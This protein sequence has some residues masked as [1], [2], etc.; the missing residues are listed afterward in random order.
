MGDGFLLPLLSQ[1][2]GTC[3]KEEMFSRE[4]VGVNRDPE[5]F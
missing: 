5:G 4:R 1:H 3:S 2:C